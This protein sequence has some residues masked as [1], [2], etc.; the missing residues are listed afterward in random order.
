MYGIPG[1]FES[2]QLDALLDLTDVS[3]LT[4]NT[5]SNA[6]HVKRADWV[7]LL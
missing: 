1:V 5:G 6:S 3:V 7:W 4:C 2:T